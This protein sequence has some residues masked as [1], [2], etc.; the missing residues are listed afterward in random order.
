MVE[1]ET[2]ELI[3]GLFSIIVVILSST[4]GI[5]IASKYPQTKQRSFLLI[6]IA[7]IGLVEIWWGVSISVLHV[8]I[9]G[10]T[11]PDQLYMFIGN[12]FLPLESVLLITGFTDLFLKEKQKMIVLVYAIIGIAF[13]I[14]FLYFL[15][16]DYSVLGTVNSP[17]DA[18][19]SII[20]TLY[21][22]LLLVTLLVIGT[23]F[24]RISLRSEVLALKLKGKLLIAGLL[25]FIFGGILDIIGDISVV[26]LI[27]ARILLMLSSFLFYGGFLLPNWMKKLFLKK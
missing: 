23:L 11:L 16:T 9:T 20:L 13:E 26:I 25:S 18:S 5:I 22:I 7:W 24:A 10:N 6:G 17:V 8:L 2:I 1:L 14:Y 12:A 19:Y 27:L 4:V 3:N 21:Q 15:F